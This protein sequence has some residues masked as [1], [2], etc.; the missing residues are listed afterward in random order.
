MEWA[1]KIQG[2]VTD[3]AIYTDNWVIGALLLCFLIIVPTITYGNSFLGGLSKSFFQ[4]RESVDTEE[5]YT[6]ASEYIMRLALLIGSF[7]T[8]GVAMTTFIRKSQPESTYPIYQLMFLFPAFTAVFFVIRQTVFSLVNKIFFGNPH[9][10]VWRYHYSSL[11]ILFYIPFYIITLA[12]VFFQLDPKTF[13][14]T[15]SL[16]LVLFEMCL[17]FKGFCIFYVKKYGGLQLFI[18]LC[19]LELM[20]LLLVGKALV[21]F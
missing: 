7:I 19:T 15:T 4:T 13:L 10:T 6:N 11:T 18:Y 9:A 20:P 1:E 3:K 21:L 5:A 14:I 8:T 12:F 16:L 17:F 2:I